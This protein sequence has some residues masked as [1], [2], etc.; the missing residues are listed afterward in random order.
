[1]TVFRPRVSVPL[2]P[3]KKE[4]EDAVQ[5]LENI[6]LCGR[7][8]VGK[9]SFAVSLAMEF[10]ARGE[11][12][13]VADLDIV[14]PYFRTADFEKLFSEAGVGLIAPMYANTNLDIPVLPPGLRAEIPR[15]GRRLLIDVGGDDDGAVA[16]GGYADALTA[17]GYSMLYLVSA[18]RE[19]DQ[20]PE[21]D[22]ALL[23]S[24]ESAS[25]L[26][27]SGIVNNTNLGPETDAKVIRQGGWYADAVAKLTGVPLLGTVIPQELERDFPAKEYFVMRRRVKPVWEL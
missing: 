13:V 22:A 24:V 7:Y 3:E 8:G 20:R 25:H 23:R 26:S 9:T 6:I 16:L 4:G 17:A 2:R 15:T 12:T 11:K 14:N 21:D 27:V 18:L 19:P 5:L 10:A 1:M